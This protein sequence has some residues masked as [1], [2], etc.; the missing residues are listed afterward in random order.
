MTGSN[1]KSKEEIAKNLLLFFGRYEHALIA[2][3]NFKKR[4]SPNG[5]ETDDLETDWKEIKKIAQ[6]KLTIEKLKGLSKEAKYLIKEPPQK[7]I[8]KDNKKDYKNVPIQ[9]VADVI[10]ASK[11]AR[12]NLFHGEKFNDE[13]VKRDCKLMLGAIN[14]L[15]CLLD[16]DEEL[17]TAFNNAKLV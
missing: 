11:R 17:K 2:T 4:I 13:D 6:E 1:S 9:S 3:G 10:E 7:Q 16:Q 15:E 14:I 5:Q 8:I 12:N